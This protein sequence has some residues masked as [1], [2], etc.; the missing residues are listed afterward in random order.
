MML[1]GAHD[2]SSHDANMLLCYFRL[3]QNRDSPS[4]L[5]VESPCTVPASSAGAFC[6]DKT[7][8]KEFGSGGLTR[9]ETPG[10]GGGR[11]GREEDEKG[12]RKKK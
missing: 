9:N 4:G 3:W 2:A 8:H 12:D 1:C 11:R 6:K 10:K 7:R 5:A